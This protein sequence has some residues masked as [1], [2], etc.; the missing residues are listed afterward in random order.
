M[1]S[2][3]LQAAIGKF[4][5]SGTLTD[6]YDQ[7][8]FRSGSLAEATNLSNSQILGR[9]LQQQAVPQYL[10]PL[11]NSGAT[12]GDRFGA[13]TAN[14]NDTT[15]SLQ[16]SSS[17]GMITKALAKKKNSGWCQNDVDIWFDETFNWFNN[18]GTSGMFSLTRLGADYRIGQN[19]LIGFMMEVDWMDTRSSQ[20]GYKTDGIGWMAGPYAAVRLFGD[21]YLD[22][23]FLYGLSNNKVSPYA[24]YTDVF[25]THRYLASARI[26]GTM[27]K[28]NWSLVPSLEYIH[29]FEA[30]RSYT[31][32][33]GLNISSQEFRLHRLAAGAEVQHR[34]KRVASKYD[35]ETALSLKGNWDA[36]DLATNNLG[37]TQASR[38]SMSAAGKISF[39]DQQSRVLSFGLMRNGLLSSQINSTGVSIFVCT[40]FQ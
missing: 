35:I 20:L 28:D 36:G 6:Y 22:G 27:T 18:Q 16:A 38:L 40:P 10:I 26:S 23:K 7:S 1:C 15:G 8:T 19:F 11:Q 14:A 31:D 13:L 29:Y 24:T 2:S 12:F 39:K 9:G 32:Y 4:A 25:K 21:I 3:D 33:Y 37:A 5:T 17:L 30:S 34:I